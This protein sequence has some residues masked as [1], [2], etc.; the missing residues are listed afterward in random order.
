M[1]LTKNVLRISIV[2]CNTV[3]VIDMDQQVC[4]N[5]GDSVGNNK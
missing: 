3:D 4:D 2:I 1:H 5:A